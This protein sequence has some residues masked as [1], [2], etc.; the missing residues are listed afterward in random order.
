MSFGT[1]A[2]HKNN[3]FGLLKPL[4]NVRF[5]L[6][7]IYGLKN[8]GGLHLLSSP[9]RYRHIFWITIFLRHT[10][11]RS[12]TRI[13]YCYPFKWFSLKYY[14]EKYALT[15]I[16]NVVCSWQYTPRTR[17]IPICLLWFEKSIFILFY[18]LYHYIDT[19][20]PGCCGFL[21]W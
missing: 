13:L 2:R 11:P 9:L 18:I 7:F 15:V 10:W 17:A 12:F 20:P 8:L 14:K 1:C 16:N 4:I 21:F 6:Y 19:P 3:N 5:V